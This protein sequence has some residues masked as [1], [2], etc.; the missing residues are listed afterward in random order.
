MANQ[1]LMDLPADQL[2][3]NYGKTNTTFDE[4]SLNSELLC[5]VYEYGLEGPS[6]VQQ[7]AIMPMIEG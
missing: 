6:S 5:S 4:M 3:S 7:R 1:G 2:E